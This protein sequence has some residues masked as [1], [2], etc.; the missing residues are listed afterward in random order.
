M[1]EL[2]R[3]VTGPVGIVATRRGILLSP[4]KGATPIQV[5]LEEAIASVIADEGSAHP[6]E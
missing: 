3:Y 1:L 5:D 4:E 6:P 2:L